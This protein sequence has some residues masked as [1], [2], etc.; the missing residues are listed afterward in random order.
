MDNFDEPFGILR[1]ASRND[2]NLSMSDDRSCDIRSQKLSLIDYRS[3]RASISPPLFQNHRESVPMA[4]PNV[5][6]VFFPAEEQAPPNTT[7]ADDTTSNHSGNS[8]VSIQSNTSATNTH[9]KLP[10]LANHKISKKSTKPEPRQSRRKPAQVARQPSK[11]PLSSKPYPARGP[12]S[13]SPNS[14]S[15]PAAAPAV[16]EPVV[17]KGK[18]NKKQKPPAQ[19]TRCTCR[20]T[21]CLKLYCECFAATGFC[22]PKCRCE[23]CHNKESLNE[24]R[25]L[26]IQETI[27][28]NPLAFKSKF[29]KIDEIN[30]KKLHSRGCNCRKTGC[31]KNYCECYHAGIGCSPLC[32]CEDC[33]ND[34]IN[35]GLDTVTAY[36]D[37]VLRKRKRR[38]Y[39]YDFYFARCK[40]QE[41]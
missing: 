6:Q 8:I 3:R 27:G 26:I 9:A 13:P 35:V 31:V 36:R 32:R 23:D 10:H 29:K 24:L 15:V 1:T 41:E 28:K 37:K 39:L 20:K 2:G 16:T 22:G 19:K 17:K 7:N 34:H 11:Q 5:S 4:A 30:V 18:N 40:A 33:R 14:T 21:K 25:Q 38:N 12:R